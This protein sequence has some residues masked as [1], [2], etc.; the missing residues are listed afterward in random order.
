MIK[1]SLE[2]LIN[3]K[4]YE[5]K[6]KVINKCDVFFAMDKITDEDYVYLLM[7]I[8]SVYEPITEEFE[9]EV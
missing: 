6:E 1:K 9:S 8:E 5:D 3:K 2:N 7:L 4:Y